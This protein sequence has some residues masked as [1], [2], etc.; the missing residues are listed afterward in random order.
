MKFILKHKIV[1]LVLMATFIGAILRL[2]HLGEI[3]ALNADEAAL[4]Y[5]A[6][7]LIKTGK[8]EH[9]NKWPLYFQ[10]FND[11]KPGL[12]VYLI[13]PMVYFFG[14]SEIS[15][16]F[17][18]A[19]I[20]ILTI[21]LI[22]LLAQELV[23]ESKNNRVKAYVPVVS[24]CILAVSPWH[25]HFSRGAWEVN[26]ATFF[27]CAGSYFFLKINENRKF[28]IVSVLFFILSLYTYHA[29]RIISPLIGL[30][31]SLL[32]FRDL[33]K[34]KKM[35][36]VSLLFSFILCIPL[37]LS[38]K[39]P[40]GLARAGGVAIWSD[41]GPEN[42]VNELRGDYANINGVVPKLLHNKPISY[43]LAILA[44]WAKHYWGEFLFLSGDDIQRNK[45]PETGQMHLL[46]IVFVVVGLYKILKYIHRKWS[47]VLIWLLV[48]PLPAA[49]TFQAPH[50]LRSESMVI[51]L[52]LIAALGFVHIFDICKNTKYI[53]KFFP[54]LFIIIIFIYVLSVLRYIHMYY[55]HMIKE[56]PFSSQYG[57]KELVEYVAPI[58]QNYSKVIITDRYDQPYILF[59]FY[60]KYDP[61]AF[62][63]DHTLTSR[64]LYGFSTVRSFSNF[65]FE[66]I[67]FVEFR[68]HYP[69]SLI[70]GTDKEILDGANISKDI[71]GSNG[72][73]YFR[74]V[75]N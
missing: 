35:V 3:P 60:M 44:N 58:H 56:Y 59:L 26:I 75:Q 18:P 50:A 41:S 14:L 38:L 6:Y 34:Y 13:L 54:G 61:Q 20:G 69:N 48:A 47:F 23:R 29:A 9:G 19:L 16:R 30:S 62:Q 8:D 37:L 28:L 71:Y 39:G 4:G 45:V 63:N 70:I 40:A 1:L 17:L 65:M 49:I 52:V 7:S 46:E 64:D 68:T 43:T 73:R 33:L 25:I 21:P 24:A 67:P 15:V 12:T 10:S 72:Y 27:I 31:L 11:Y 53:K 32:Y 22:Y 42:R 36:V 74:I 51:P 5:N 66:S 57:V 55:V 2:Y